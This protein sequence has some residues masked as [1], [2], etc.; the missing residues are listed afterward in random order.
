MTKKNTTPHRTIRSRFVLC[1]NNEGC[2]VSLEKQK[3]YRVI[4]DSQATA[5]NLLRVIDE[6]GEDYLY[7]TSFFVPISVPQRARAAFVAVA[8]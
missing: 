5:H 7:P 3:I 4:S 8:A 6:S 1:L 2:D